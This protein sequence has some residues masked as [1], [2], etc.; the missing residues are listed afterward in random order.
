MSRVN[1]AVE[2]GYDI[3]AL[4][5][6]LLVSQLSG[7]G[8]PGGDTGPQDAAPI[9]STYQR[10]DGTFYVKI[11]DTDA[12]SDWQAFSFVLSAGYTPQNGDPTVGDSLEEAI[13]KLDGNQDDIQS[14]LGIAQGD[15]DFGTFTGALLSDNLTAKALFQEIETAVEEIDQNVDDLISLTGVAENS[16]D[17]GT[18]TGLTISDN[19]SIKGALQELE[20]ALELISGGVTVR[21]RR[22]T[23]V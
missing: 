6:N 16:T 21:A 8:A 10:T 15:V 19:N 2:Q 3:Y 22:T 1:F 17:L 5:G 4:N 14:A 20:T 11:A 23:V 18:F 7:S 9:G 12:T 13:E